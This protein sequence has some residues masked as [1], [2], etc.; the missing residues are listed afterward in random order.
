MNEVNNSFSSV[1]PETYTNCKGWYLSLISHVVS[2]VCWNLISRRSKTFVLGERGSLN[3]EKVRLNT[4]I[5]IYHLLG[6]L[7]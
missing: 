3:N 7:N 1:I 4:S 5:C 2:F 6:V